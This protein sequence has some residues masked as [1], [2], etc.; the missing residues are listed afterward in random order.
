MGKLFFIFIRKII[1]W[2]TKIT[3]LSEQTHN[4]IDK[5]FKETKSIP[6]TQNHDHSLSCLG[7]GTIII[8][9]KKQKTRFMGLSLPSS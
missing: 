1:Q 5:S 6:L 3:T 9:I 2:K 7:T 4:L 8:I